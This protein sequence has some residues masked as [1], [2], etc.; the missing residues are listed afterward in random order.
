MLEFI[1]FD[2]PHVIGLRI[3]G[4]IEKSDILEAIEAVKPMMADHDAIHIYVEME[5][6]DGVSLEAMWEDLCF[7]LP[8]LGHFKR[9]AVVSSEDWVE[10]ATA[11][12][13]RL[14]PNIKVRCF[15]P[16]EKDAAIKW[17]SEPAD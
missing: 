11:I 13:D 4:R 12:G 10:T 3:D 15:T 1:K 6:F 5:S 17:I 9:K 14:F 7:A 2:A 16:E 8:N